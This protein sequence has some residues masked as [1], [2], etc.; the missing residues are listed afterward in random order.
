[1]LI[2]YAR[3]YAN[4]MICMRAYVTK[5]DYYYTT[6]TNNPMRK[7]AT[8]MSSCSKTFCCACHLQPKP[9]LCLQLIFDNQFLFQRMVIVSNK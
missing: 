1:M 2:I 4:K 8:I 6:S 9:F 3:T 7:A 5:Y